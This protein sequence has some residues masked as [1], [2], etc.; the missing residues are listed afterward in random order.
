MAF[1]TRDFWLFLRKSEPTGASGGAWEGRSACLNSL[2]PAAGGAAL[3]TAGNE[4]TQE[5]RAKSPAPETP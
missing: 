3:K 5:D 2:F 4:D 1:K